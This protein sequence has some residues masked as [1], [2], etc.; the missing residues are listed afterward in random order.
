[1]ENDIQISLIDHVNGRRMDLEVALGV[2]AIELY[3]GLNSALG[4]GTDPQDSRS[5]YLA[6]ENPIALL[7]GDHTLREFGVRNG[8]ILH[9]SRH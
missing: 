4:W 1:M 8:S 2:T 6:C 5:C 3:A 7:R 9:Y